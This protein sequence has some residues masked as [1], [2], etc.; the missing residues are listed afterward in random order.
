MTA[1]RPRHLKED[2]L[3]FYMDLVVH[4]ILNNNQ[5]VLGYL[6]LVMA[7]PACDKALRNYAEKA[8]SHVRTSTMLVENCKRVMAMRMRDL[9]TLK[10]ID[11]RPVLERSEKEVSRFF[12]DKKII[13]RS[14]QTPK[15]ALVLGNSDAENLIINAMINVVRLDPNDTVVL[16]VTVSPSVF[17]GRKCWT[18]TVEDDR[19]LLPLSLKG[20]DIKSVHVLDSS[21]AVK[22]TTLLFSKMIAEALGGDFDAYE[23]PDSK[24]N[25]GAGF[26]ITLRRADKR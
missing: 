19:A 18:V 24:D 9:G 23:L 12:P 8:F 15:E 11:L 7:N 1:S 10:P 20:R 13:V 4:D 5:A 17:R 2:H 6:E 14:V 16:R 21:V 3:D 22:L 26:A 25:V